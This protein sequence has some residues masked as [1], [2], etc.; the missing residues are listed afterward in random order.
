[1]FISSRLGKAGK[2]WIYDLCGNLVFNK[3][4]A[5]LTE[6]N[7]FYIWN[8]NNNANKKVSSGLYLY[9]IKMGNSYK[10]G[11]IAVIN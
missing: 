5:A 1:M 9:I 2:I 3:K 8:G 7:N 4:I 10:K 11:K 6:L